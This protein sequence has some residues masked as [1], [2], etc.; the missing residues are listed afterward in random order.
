MV[1]NPNQSN[2]SGDS[3]NDTSNKAPLK[4]LTRFNVRHIVKS[5]IGDNIKALDLAN[6]IDATLDNP[7]GALR[8]DESGRDQKLTSLAKTVLS[9]KD[10]TSYIRKKVD[11]LEKKIDK[12]GAGG[13]SGP[14][15]FSGLGLAAGI[16]LAE[17]LTGGL[18]ARTLTAIGIGRLLMA[19]AGGIT[20]GYLLVHFWVSVAP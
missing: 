16:G 20:L 2:K 4:N 12:M 5:V 3:T 19:A 8:K 15:S 6:I 14:G 1:D 18:L 9:V 10:D 17:L 11:K 7:R 13:A